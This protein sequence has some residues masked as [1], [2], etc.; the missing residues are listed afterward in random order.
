M[1]G[2]LLVDHES[3]TGGPITAMRGAL[4]L[5]YLERLKARD[6]H[7]RYVELLPAQWREQILYMTAMS[8]V[9]VELAWVHFETCDRLDLADVETIEQGYLAAK[10]AAPVMLGTLFRA[11]GLTPVG[12][13]RALGRVWD[14]IH[15][16]GGC[17]ALQTGPKDIYIEQRGNMG[18]RSRFYRTAGMG[19]YRGLAEAFC[20]R[21][22]VR[23]AP[24]RAD[25]PD[26]FAVTISW[27]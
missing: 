18:A 16:G 9:P 6:Y 23:P 25:D 24:T 27:V 13:V 1:N 20:K 7:A 14:R 12:A 11:A 2:E 8:W 4:L 21:A 15:V 5:S 17:I 19:F 22:Y 10:A 26:R 3:P